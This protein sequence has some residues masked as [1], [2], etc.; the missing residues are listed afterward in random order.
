MKFESELILQKNTQKNLH[1]FD[2]KMISSEF[3]YQEKRFDTLAFDEKS[4]SFAIIEYKNKLDFQVLSQAKSYYGLLLENKSVY[5]D[6]YNEVFSDDLKVNDFDFDNTRVLIIGPEFS[7]DQLEKAH[8]PDYP[9]EIWKADVDD[10]HCITYKNVVTNEIR[11]LQVG[12]DDLKLTEDE[13]LYNKTR[14][15]V[16][17]Y[18]TIKNSVEN[19][20][21]DA[22]MNILIDAFSYWVNDKLI[23]KFL[24]LKN[25]LKV[26]FY[27][28]ELKDST[29]KL[30]DIEGKNYEGNTYYRFK[31]KS[32]EDIDYFIELFKQIYR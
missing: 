2:L 32:N 1:L 28:N 26:Y 13:L 30:E 24:F 17:L 23:C 29:G 21:P 6:K 15:T 19:E 27:T 4:N 3:Q 10:N 9:F 18:N 11:H 20:F 14:K 8:T 7:K 5:V 31:L 22:K 25:Y 12:E 16:Y